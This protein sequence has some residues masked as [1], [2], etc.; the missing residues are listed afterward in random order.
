MVIHARIVKI[1]PVRFSVELTSK[2]SDLRDSQQKFRPKKDEYYDYDLEHQDQFKI[3]EKKRKEQHRQTYTKR[4][5]AHPQFKNVGY[6]EAVVYLKDMDVGDALIRPSSKGSD[7]LT[8]TWKIGKSCFQHV[9]VL[10][11]KKINAFSIGKRLIIEGEDYEDL[12]EILARYIGAMAG[13]VRE[14][15]SHKN[16]K[17]NE[18]INAM[19]TNNLSQESQTDKQ[20]RKIFKIH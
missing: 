20:V 19:F 7:H 18:V 11:E 13:Y 16:Y 2:T 12:D 5:I 4:I 17:D 3:D 8:I 1:D 15:I 6:K 9:D 14:I 10:E